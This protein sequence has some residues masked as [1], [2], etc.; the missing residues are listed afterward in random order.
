MRVVPIQCV[1]RAS[2]RQACTKVK[3]SSSSS[4]LFGLLATIRPTPRCIHSRAMSSVPD[5]ASSAS[6]CVTICFSLISYFHRF[7][8]YLAAN[9]PV[10]SLRPLKPYASSS[11]NGLFEPLS[12]SPFCLFSL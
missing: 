2:A 4:I 5:A 3:T 8:H 7:L 1:L 6:A 9:E 10:L 12:P 11:L